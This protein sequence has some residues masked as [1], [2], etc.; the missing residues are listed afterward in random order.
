MRFY[1]QQVYKLLSNELKNGI[2]SFFCNLPRI[3]RVIAFEYFMRYQ[4]S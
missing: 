4:P 1:D 2:L 3:I